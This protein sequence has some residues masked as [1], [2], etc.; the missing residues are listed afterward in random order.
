MIK[1]F[2]HTGKENNDLCDRFLLDY[3]TETAQKTLAE[4]F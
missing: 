2:I 4:V 1:K 3:H